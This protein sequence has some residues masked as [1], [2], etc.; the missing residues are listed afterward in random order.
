MVTYDL[1]GRQAYGNGYIVI[2][3]APGK[4][5]PAVQENWQDIREPLPFRDH[6]DC[7]IGVL[8]GVGDT[9]VYAVDVDILDEETVEYVDSVLRGLGDLVYRVGKAPKRL[10]L[11]KSSEPGITKMA[12]AVYESGGDE[13]GKIEILGK[14][15]QFVAFG[16]HPDT[17]KPYRWPEDSVLSRESIDLPEITRE[18]MAELISDFKT[19]A[20]MVGF[21]VKERQPDRIADPN[22]VYEADNPIF[23]KLPLAQ[24]ELDYR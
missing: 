12:T 13:V 14:G 11:F 1:Y 2:P 18:Q 23:E 4:K 21:K 24:T 22:H 16:A 15:Q 19:Y 7:G 3:I 5:Y 20:D 17:K 6:L 9:P 8:C 10:Y